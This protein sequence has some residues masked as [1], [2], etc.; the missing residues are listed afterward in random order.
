MMRNIF[1]LARIAWYLLLEPSLWRSFL[2]AELQKNGR[3]RA[4]A[5]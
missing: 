5:F 1:P 3:D 4:S 2:L